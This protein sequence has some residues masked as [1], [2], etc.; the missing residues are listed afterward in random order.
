MWTGVFAVTNELT[1]LGSQLL[2]SCAY[3]KTRG[4]CGERNSEPLSIFFPTKLV[5]RGCTAAGIVWAFWDCQPSSNFV[6]NSFKVDFIGFSWR[7]Q[8]TA[9]SYTRPPPHSTT[10]TKPHAHKALPLFC[11][12]VIR[13]PGVHH[14]G[15]TWSQLVPQVSPQPST[16]Y[17]R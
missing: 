1:S 9:P 16:V 7:I 2:W 12:E 8:S 17:M 4:G 15:N 11:P 14:A 6:R 10:N 13:K 5:L 3:R